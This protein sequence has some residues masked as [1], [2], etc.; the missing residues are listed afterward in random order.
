MPTD[1]SSNN[2][3]TEQSTSSI[4]KQ[5]L[6]EDTSPKTPE[7]LASNSAQ[8]TG[9]EP[10]PKRFRPD[11]TSLHSKIAELYGAPPSTWLRRYPPLSVSDTVGR[12]RA[13]D[14]TKIKELTAEIE[15]FARE[16]NIQLVERS[17]IKALRFGSQYYDEAS[18]VGAHSEDELY[19][20]VL[21]GCIDPELKNFSAAGV[22]GYGH[23]FQDSDILKVHGQSTSDN[24]ETIRTENFSFHKINGNKSVIL[25]DATRGCTAAVTAMLIL[26]QGGAPDLNSLSV[27][28]LGDTETMMGDLKA[29]GFRPLRTKNS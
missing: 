8:E 7:L 12:P 25:Q 19:M 16:H 5:P 3:A 15:S 24:L 1:L 21:A 18:Q 13:L 14:Q 28:N 26:D 6:Q 11:T 29:A 22:H 17:A 27:R 20:K 2:P 9:G 23:S 4:N 10:L